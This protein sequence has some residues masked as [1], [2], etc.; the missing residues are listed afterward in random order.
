[1]DRLAARPGLQVILPHLGCASN[2]GLK[3]S[4]I[5]TRKK[6]MSRLGGQGRGGTPASEVSGRIPKGLHDVRRRASG[7][8][9]V[10]CARWLPE[11]GDEALPCRTET[12]GGLASR[13]RL[14]TWNERMAQ[15]RNGG[16]GS[17]GQQL[18]PLDHLPDEHAPAQRGGDCVPEMQ[19]RAPGL[20]WPHQPEAPGALRG[21]GTVWHVVLFRVGLSG[22]ES[23]WAPSPQTD[24]CLELTPHP[25]TRW[26]KLQSSG[27][28]GRDDAAG[29]SQ[30]REGGRVTPFCSPRLAH[31]SPWWVPQ[32]R[33]C[34]PL[35][36]A[37]AR[38]AR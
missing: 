37:G 20:R 12:G 8:Q 14:F 9:K 4:S 22:A 10:G 29:L 36:W 18:A 30:E 34:C 25:S 21:L 1:M 35:G 32:D 17:P 13:V 15:R 2:P 38:S 7:T 31:G 24:I 28:W 11:G 26:A 5:L 3:C 6:L 19:A 33:R 23:W 16:S 27:F